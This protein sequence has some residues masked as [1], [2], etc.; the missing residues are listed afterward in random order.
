MSVRV[1]HRL[2]VLTWVRL[3]LLAGGLLT[4]AWTRWAGSGLDARVLSDVV[5]F[6]SQF[7]AVGGDRG[8]PQEGQIWGGDPMIGGDGRGAVWIGTW[9]SG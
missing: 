3:S 1:H 8:F 7:V 2:P 4:V 5:L 9:T 6:G